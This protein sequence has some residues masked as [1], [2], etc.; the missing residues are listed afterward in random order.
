MSCVVAILLITG[1]FVDM[2]LPVKQVLFRNN[3]NVK[4]VYNV[5]QIAGGQEVDKHFF[6]RGISV[7]E[8]SRC[9][10]VYSGIE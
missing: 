5:P 3:F 4:V 6:N 1:Q 2:K 9:E 8:A 7:I 10:G